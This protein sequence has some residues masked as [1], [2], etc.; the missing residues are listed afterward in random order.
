MTDKTIKMVATRSFLGSEGQWKRGAGAGGQSSTP[1]DKERAESLQRKGLA[2]S[3]EDYAKSRQHETKPETGRSTKPDNGR[4]TKPAPGH[5]TKPAPAGQTKA[6]KAAAAK[7]EAKAKDEKEKGGGTDTPPAGPVDEP[8]VIEGNAIKIVRHT[9]GKGDKAF[10]VAA[11][12]FVGEPDTAYSVFVFRDGAPAVFTAD[13]D[14][15][16]KLSE[17]KN[18]V[19]LDVVRTEKADEPA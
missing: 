16:K 6:Q 7:A 1:V 18:A 8:V 3:E 9:S 12:E 11:A 15:T 17:D 4:T 14:E 10:E 5:S 2:L 19:T 13:A